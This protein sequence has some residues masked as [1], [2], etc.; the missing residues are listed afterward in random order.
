MSAHII[1]LNNFT[2]IPFTSLAICIKYIIKRVKTGKKM[3][4]FPVLQH[5]LTILF[6]FAFSI[7]IHN[8]Q[9]YMTHIVTY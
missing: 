7:C 4:D 5:C 9:F 1:I 2:D 3:Y 6:G 8:H